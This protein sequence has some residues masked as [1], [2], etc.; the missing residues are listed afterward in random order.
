MV[1]L[2]TLRYLTNSMSNGSEH[3]L[4]PKSPRGISDM[5]STDGGEHSDTESATCMD[6][7]GGAYISDETWLSSE[8][9]VVV[10]SQDNF[11][12]NHK[13]N[14]HS[15][16][17]YIDTGLLFRCYD[18]VFF[19]YAQ[20]TGDHTQ[21][22]I[23]GALSTEDYRR[24]VIKK[25]EETLGT[26]S[27]YFD[28][29]HNVDPVM[30]MYRQS[31]DISQVVERVMGSAEPLL[32]T[33]CE[34][35]EHSLWAIQSRADIAALQMAFARVD[36]MYIA[37][38]HHRSAAAARSN[39]KYILA[40]VFPDS[41]LRVLPYNRCITT[42]GTLSP[43]QYINRIRC[44]FII[45]PLGPTSSI[46]PTPLHPHEMSMFLGDTWYSLHPRPRLL[47]TSQAAD[48]ILSLDPEILHRCLLKPIL[49]IE[50]PRSDTRLVYVCGKQGWG[51]LERLVQAGEVAVAFLLRHVSVT[52]IM[53]V[54]D[55]G[56]LLPPK[57]CFIVNII[58]M[59]VF[60]ICLVLLGDLL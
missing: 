18:E 21:I 10:V 39:S 44:N 52:E 53:H 59:D 16:L 2:Q 32:R 1:L 20:T 60:L 25:H 7:P 3:S 22:G 57:V 50:C 9:P 14:M 42:L 26:S 11:C 47:S 28:K 31:A 29:V 33:S 23:C 49:G 48:P 8:T 13:I 24:G 12:G 35:G 27:A 46:D 34:G 15:M 43:R 40:A 37:D 58:Y 19:V 17:E 30:M 55:S 45:Q 56:C 6:I 41:Q 38:G 51:E 4:T 54:A 5:D 36:T